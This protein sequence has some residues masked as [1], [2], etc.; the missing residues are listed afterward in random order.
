MAVDVYGLQIFGTLAGEPV[1]NFLHYT[2]DAVT[3]GDP[4]VDGGKCIDAWKAGVRTDWLGVLPQ[5]YFLKGYKA[6]RLNNTLGPT[7]AE[8]EAAGTIGTQAVNCDNSSISPVIL[9][10]YHG[11][12]RWGNGKIFMPGVDASNMTENALSPGII[13]LY[14]ALMATLSVGMSAGGNT[15]HQIVWTPDRPGVPGA[16]HTILGWSLSLKIGIQNGRLKPVL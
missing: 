8:F 3:S 4:V 5:N 14:A 2:C 15:Y 13:A 9:M 6:R 1:E 10:P 11:A 7:V 16:A 12:G